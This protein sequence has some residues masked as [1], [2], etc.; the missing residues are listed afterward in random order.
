MM[1]GNEGKTRIPIYDTLSRAGFDPDKDVFQTPIMET[2][3]NSCFW[4]GPAPTG[5]RGLGSGGFLV[6]WD[7]RTSLEGLYAAGTSPVFGAGCHGESHTMGRYAARKAAAYART[8]PDAVIDRRQ[9]D[10]EKALAYRPLRQSKRGVGW[11][12]LNAAI[13][14]VMQDYCG[15]YKNELTLN[16]GL[17]LLKELKEHE[18]AAAYAANPHELGRTLECFSLISV[19][20][21]VLQASLARKCSSAYLDFYRLD[22]P[23]LDPPEWEKLLPIR[24]EDGQ[25]AVREL[26][27]DFHL[28]AP[29]AATYEENYRRVAAASAGR[30]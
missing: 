15:R 25:V 13:A 19:G 14:R 17:S 2:Y 1:V 10:A 9:V 6:D 22:Y 16:R 12:E 8:C 21:M 30:S 26:P 3:E 23:Q 24:Q 18:G 20:E 5:V 7:L 28:R 11:K 27:L 4:T 29:Y